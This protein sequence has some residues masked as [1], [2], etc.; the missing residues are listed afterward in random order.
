MQSAELSDITG[1]DGLVHV[2]VLETLRALANKLERK[3]NP[4]FSCDVEKQRCY[5]ASLEEP[6]DDIERSY[7]QYR[8]QMWLKGR[9]AS[10][11][12]N[13]ASLP[14][15]LGFLLRRGS[16]KE[17]G[18]GAVGTGKRAVFVGDSSVV[19]RIPDELWDTYE[20]IVVDN[21]QGIGLLK[22]DQAYLLQVWRRYPLSWHFILKCAIKVRQYR[23]VLE[24]WNPDAIIACSEY[25]FTS[26]L[27]TDYLNR[28]NVDHINVMHGNKL[29]FI[30]DSFFR[31]NT[32]YVWDDGFA[33]LFDRLRAESSQFAVS[34]P[35]GLKFEETS[36]KVTADFTYYLGGE[37]IKQFD[38][39]IDILGILSAR[40]AKVRMRPHPLYTDGRWLEKVPPSIEV[41]NPL[42]MALEQSVLSSACVMSLYSTVLIQAYLNGV[43]VVIDDLSD[44]VRF[45][46]LK[47]LEFALLDAEHRLLSDVLAEYDVACGD[48]AG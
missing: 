40:G 4:L 28:N 1:L 23:R 8:C 47:Q 18:D 25:S 5:L 13:L 36:A 7:D 33:K 16:G 44:P 20:D 6:H 14:L 2:S 38:R 12:I 27:L 43:P 24:A 45:R 21:K 22:K 37:D 30:R 46:K 3:R 39:L 32:C 17:E 35:R 31:F 15:L 10:L 19:D 9:P 29:F 48:I 42:E 11:V 34:L 26:S 41:E